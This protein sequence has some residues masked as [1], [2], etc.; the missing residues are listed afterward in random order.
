MWLTTEEFNFVNA[1]HPQDVNGVTTSF[2]C[3]PI[4][5]AKY[6]SM[7]AVLQFATCSTVRIYA[8]YSSTATVTAGSTGNMCIGRYRVNSAGGAS[9]PSTADLLG[10]YGTLTTTGSSAVL[11]TGTTDA[12]FTPVATTPNAAIYLEIKSDDLPA[13]YPYVAVAISTSAQAALFSCTYVLKP[14][15]PQNVMMPSAT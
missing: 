4:N 1:S 2:P 15:Y 10:A 12:V 8:H 14:R 11:Y 5:M 3:L 7:V 6:Q 13:G 9:T